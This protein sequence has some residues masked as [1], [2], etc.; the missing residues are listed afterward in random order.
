MPRCR[1]AIQIGAE[2]LA[3]YKAESS[4]LPAGVRG[5]LS[6]EMKKKK[7]HFSVA[8][9][10]GVGGKFFGAHVSQNA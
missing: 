8:S 1:D 6:I 9:G 10:V 4:L 5:P 3:G 7:E 2:E